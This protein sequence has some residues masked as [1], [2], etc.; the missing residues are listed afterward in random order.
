M[1][2]KMKAAELY[3]VF[4]ASPLLTEAT[5]LIVEAD[6]GISVTEIAQKLHKKAPTIHRALQ[7][8]RSLSLVTINQEGRNMTYAI[9]PGKKTAVTHIL[10][11]LYYPTESYVVGELSHPSLKVQV[12]RDVEFAG[13][14]FK[15]Q[16]PLIYEYTEFRSDVK[17]EVAGET[18]TVGVLVLTRLDRRDMLSLVGELFDL[19]KTKVKGYVLA[20]I[21]D[22]ASSEDFSRL[23]RFLGDL[24]DKLDISVTPVL[25]QKKDPLKGLKQV[26]DIAA[27]RLRQ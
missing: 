2:L 21:E 9:L 14:C 10:A 15:H 13:I 1:V 27:N 16:I 24:Q 8:L 17:E 26:Q 25:V 11:Q 12:S 19:H 6:H 4:K 3:S 7:K 22:G 23:G 18:S 20:V 5:K